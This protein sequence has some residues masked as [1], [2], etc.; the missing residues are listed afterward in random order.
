M[1]SLIMTVRSLSRIGILPI[2]PKLI[3]YTPL[4]YKQNAY[5]LPFMIRPPPI[6]D[7]TQYQGGI[8]NEYDI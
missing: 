3:Q 6:Q 4:Q 2:E 7:K 5:P 1:Y 8:S